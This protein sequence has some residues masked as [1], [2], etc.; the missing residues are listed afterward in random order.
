MRDLAYSH[1]RARFSGIC[2]EWCVRAAVLPLILV[3]AVSAQDFPERA[4]AVEPP[5][6]SESTITI[7][8]QVDEVQLVFT[9]TDK[10]GR[11]VDELQ[12][13]DFRLLDNDRPP[14]RVYNFQQ[15]SD[16]PLQ[17]VLLMDISSSIN[18]RFNF[19]QQAAA[20]FLKNVLRPGVDSAA[21]ISFGSNVQRVQPMTHNPV[22]WETAIYCLSAF[23]E[24]AL[25][26]AIR[27]GSKSFRPEETARG[28][29]KVMI[30]MTDGADTVSAATEERALAAAAESDATV[31]VVDASIPGSLHNEGQLFLKKL[32]AISGGSVLPASENS[33]LKRALQRVER[34]LRTQ[35]SLSYKPADFETDGTYRSIRM[36]AQKPKLTVQC[37]QGYYARAR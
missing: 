6:G 20:M 29:R 23:G 25:Y 8:K 9:V 14:E 30:I 28:A 17:V 22:E 10:S 3:V 11:F 33:E 21:V 16:L 2:R 4:A 36:S 24:T 35:Y 27:M 26:D 34:V 1:V 13:E 12:M 19:E 5:T 37:R 15:R 32:T 18:S 7:S 31:L